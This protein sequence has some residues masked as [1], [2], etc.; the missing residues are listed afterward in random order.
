MPINPVSG[1][2]FL[3][4]KTL[5]SLFVWVCIIEYHGRGDVNNKHLFLIALG[6]RSQDQSQIL[7]EDL[8]LDLE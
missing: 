2:F 6:T 1:H 8:L 4:V 3:G 5:M 7:S